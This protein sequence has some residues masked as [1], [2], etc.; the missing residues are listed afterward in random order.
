MFGFFDKS[1]KKQ[2]QKEYDSLLSRAFKA[3]RNGDVR[4]YSR[5]TAEAEAVR[6]KIEVLENAP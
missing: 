4:L 2:W 1:P 3:Q 5:L 6:E